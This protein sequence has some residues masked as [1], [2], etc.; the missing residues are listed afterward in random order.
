MF[1][2]VLLPHKIHINIIIVLRISDTHKK[3]KQKVLDV[4][5]EIIAIL[6]DALNP[7]IIHLV[8]DIT[9]NLNSK[10]PGVRATAVNALEASIAHL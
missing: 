10:D 1:G 3:V 6:E 8:E 2:R 4:L 7:V 5:A 9:N